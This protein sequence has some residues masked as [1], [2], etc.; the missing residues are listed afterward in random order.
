MSLYANGIIDCFIHGAE[1]LGLYSSPN[2]CCTQESI[3]EKI[4]GR[5]DSAAAIACKLIETPSSAELHHEFSKEI[6]GVVALLGFAES[7]ELSRLTLSF[8]YLMIILKTCK[9]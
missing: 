4:S 1:S 7:Y 8:V 5:G 2:C 9:F 6:L 3:R